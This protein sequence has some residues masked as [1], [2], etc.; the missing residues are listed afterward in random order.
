LSEKEREREREREKKRERERRRE[1]ERERERTGEKGRERE[2][3]RGDLNHLSVHQWIRS[4][5]HDS[6]QP[7]SPIGVLFNCETSTTALCDTTGIDIYIYIYIICL[8]LFS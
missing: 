3:K 2:R 4:A 1:K 8:F 6:Q 5:I 7:I